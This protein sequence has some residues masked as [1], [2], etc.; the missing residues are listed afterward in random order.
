[1][2][3]DRPGAIAMAI[4]MSRDTSGLPLEEPV[5]GVPL[6]TI[7]QYFLDDNTGA[8]TTGSRGVGGDVIGVVAIKLQQADHL[9]RAGHGCAGG[10][11]VAKII[12]NVSA[13]KTGS[14]SGRG[15]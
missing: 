3:L 11:S 1:M 7:Q 12:S 6:A 4:S 8:A 5:V 10:I 9:P 15:A 14:A 13:A 2:I